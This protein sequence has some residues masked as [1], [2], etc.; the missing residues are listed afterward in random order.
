MVEVALER[1]GDAA[2]DVDVDMRPAAAADAGHHRQRIDADRLIVVVDR[3][4]VVLLHEKS[5]AAVVVG[6]RI[7]RVELHRLVEI[8]HG[9]VVARFGEIGIAAVVER[10][11]RIGIYSDRLVI[12]RDRLVDVAFRLVGDAAAVVGRRITGIAPDRL[13]I[14]GDRMV[15]I[16]FRLVG[17]AAVVEER[18]ELLVVRDAG[19]DHRRAGG[20]LVVGGDA[21]APFA[22]PQLLRRRAGDF[23]AGIGLASPGIAIGRRSIRP[24]DGDARD[25]APALDKDRERPRDLA[26]IG[27][28]K[29]LVRPL[30][31]VRDPL[32]VEKRPHDLRL[33]GEVDVLR[34]VPDESRDVLG[35]E[36]RRDDAGEVP[37]RVE[38]RSAAVAG[39]HR[40][41]DLQIARVV[42]ESGECAHIA[43]RQGGARRQQSRQRI[44]ESDDGIAGAHRRAAGNAA[45][46]G[47]GLGTRRRA[48]SFVGS[49]ATITAVSVFFD[50]NCTVMASHR[51]T[52]WALVRIS[53]RLPITMPEP[54]TEPSADS[55]PVAPVMSA[56]TATAVRQA[57]TQVVTARFMSPPRR[58]RGP[59]G[60]GSHISAGG[61]HRPESGRRSAL[62]HAGARCSGR[63]NLAPSETIPDLDIRSHVFSREFAIDPLKDSS[64]AGPAEDSCPP[65]ARIGWLK[66]GG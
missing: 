43:D 58:R 26:D 37:A 34:N 11:R 40:R 16:A 10:R 47:G 20:D 33:D 62:R 53:P 9:A 13:G 39:L 41:R 35:V 32:A 6:E 64:I 66:G 12:V 31:F 28:R 52:T 65:D 3:A 42:L 15:E 25:A 14:V 38:Q 19:A 2:V 48:R 56:S 22:P 8:H 44:A 4:V 18:G 7:L 17:D 55:A 21:V 45:T 29:L 60:A 51:S 1:I 46:A 36:L 59:R 5:V 61:D 24:V 27:R 30:R 23:S 57:L 50:A 49:R 54:V 63:P